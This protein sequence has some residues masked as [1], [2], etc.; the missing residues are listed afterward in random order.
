GIQIAAGHVPDLPPRFLV[1]AS[2]F[3]LEAGAEPDAIAK[4][5][6]RNLAQRQASRR[7]AAQPS[8]AALVA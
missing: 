3:A 5:V 8:P 1:S 6:I 4:L 2:R 7:P